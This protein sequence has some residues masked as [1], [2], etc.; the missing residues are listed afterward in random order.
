M[1]EIYVLNTYQFTIICGFALGTI[2]DDPLICKMIERGER[3][4]KL[5]KVADSISD[6]WSK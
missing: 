6:L 1:H 2:A 3:P 5:I 4:E